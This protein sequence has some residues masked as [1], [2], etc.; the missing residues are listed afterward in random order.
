MPRISVTIIA[1]DEAE[2]LP[3][4]LAS[5][6]WADEVVVIDSGSTD[7]TPDLARA[8]GARVMVTH[9]RGYGAQKNF[10]AEQ[11]AHDWVFNLDSDER[12]LPALA[13]AIRARP[14]A[15]PCVAYRVARENRL[16]GRVIGHWPWSWDWQARLYDRRRAR[17]RAA[18]VH[19][20][21]LVD[22]PIGRLSGVLDH[23]SYRDWA[24]YDRRQLRYAEL[25]AGQAAADGRRA[26]ACDRLLR[27]TSTFLR[28]YLVRGMWLGGG[29]GLRMAWR[30]AQ[31]AGLK[32][33][34]LAERGK[35]AAP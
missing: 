16:A 8:A 34:L 26:G 24:D 30:A 25:W 9:W 28:H 19:E 4:A 2:R 23:F 6:G 33:R 20:S 32:Y 14:D 18:A 17:F 29:L 11:A 3:A 15:P 1:Q 5:V 7:G 21:L 10:A 35:A 22:G 12:V 13:A 27:P 31:G